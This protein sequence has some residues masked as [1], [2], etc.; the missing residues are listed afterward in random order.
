MG[1]W[2]TTQSGQKQSLDGALLLPC[3]T[4]L[5][6]TPVGIYSIDHDGRCTQI[7]PA[8]L[9]LMGYSEDECLGRDMHTLIHATTPKT[10][11]PTR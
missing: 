8:A 4:A 9:S 3:V 5:N 6:N 2:Q 1:E 7:N 10:V 11:L